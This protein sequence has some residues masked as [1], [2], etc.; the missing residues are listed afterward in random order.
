MDF[1][2]SC[3][4]DFI[5]SDQSTNLYFHITID[6]FRHTVNSMS[7]N[8]KESTNFIVNNI[9]VVANFHIVNHFNCIN[10]TLSFNFNLSV[11]FNFNNNFS[12]L[13][14]YHQFPFL[15]GFIPDK[16]KSCLFH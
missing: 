11:S 12:N 16:I 3:S 8:T 15:I 2:P 4:F 1:K 10:Y 6:C 9:A 7:F 13:A 5:S 14:N